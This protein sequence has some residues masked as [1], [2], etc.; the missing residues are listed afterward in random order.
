MRIR[1]A[2]SVIVLVASVFSCIP[3]VAAPEGPAATVARSLE[4]RR[5]ARDLRF[6]TLDHAP[7]PWRR[8]EVQTAPKHH[9]RA[10]WIAIGAAAGAGGG[11]FAGAAL[12]SLT[13]NAESLTPS[14]VVGGALGGL[15]GAL[16]AVLLTRN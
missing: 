6:D 1:R 3:L 14:A 7:S 9:R 4:L 8:V 16:I 13:E 10:L 11:A 2:A 12:Q 5:T 15:G